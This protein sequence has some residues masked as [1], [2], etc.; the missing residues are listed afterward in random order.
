[1]KKFILIS[2]CLLIILGVILLNRGKEVGTDIVSKYYVNGSKTLYYPLFNREK[3]DNYI[4]EYLNSNMNY[5]EKLF[6]DYDYVD[7][8]EGLT[9]TFYFYGESPTGVRYKKESL[10]IDMSMESVER[11]DA[12]DNS[13]TSHRALT[14]KESK[15]IA[16]TF[17]DGPNYNSSKMV[18]VLSKWGMRATFFV[19]GNRA[20]KEADIL[21]KMVDKG[22]EI[23]NHTYSHKLLT[24]LSSEAIREEIMR[25][26]RVIFDI[27]GRDVNLVRP[28]YGSSNKRVRSSIDR[29]IIVWDI[30]TLD[31]KYHNSKRLSDYILK[32]VQ[33][34]DIVLMHDIY[35]ATVNG[36]DMVIP[37]LMERG[38]RVVSVSELFSI[39]GKELENGKVYGRAY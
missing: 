11:V 33:D 39:K 12:K 37:K 20:E 35:S 15:Y 31:W 22:M 21:L 18:D 36:V 25:T 16:F 4:W 1:M 7:N 24:K 30:D 17:D 26:D 10:Y 9:I 34:G 8:K 2:F 13:T 5:G 38:Y 32:N 23:G 28:S 29:P 3:I 6:L 27:T 14:K 19:V